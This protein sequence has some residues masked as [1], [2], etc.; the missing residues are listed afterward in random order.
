MSKAAQVADSVGPFLRA[1]RRSEDEPSSLL[2]LITK[3]QRDSAP[4]PGVSLSELAKLLIQTEQRK[5]DEGPEVI[6][7]RLAQDQTPA[8][9]LLRKSGLPMIVFARALQS[10]RDT[11]LLQI[12]DEGE[13]V[14]V[15]ATPLGRQ[16][17]QP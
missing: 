14:T 16:L 17:V 10:L 12:S 4:Q 15:Q 9:R 7:L 5:D 3:I 6:V 2:S 1:M 8:E 11:G 13:R